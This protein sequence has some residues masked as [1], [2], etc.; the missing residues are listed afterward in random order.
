MPVNLAPASLFR[1]VDHG[2]DQQLADTSAAD[3]G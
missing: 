3:T 1:L 2:F